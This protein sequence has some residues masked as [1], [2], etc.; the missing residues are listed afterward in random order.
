MNGQAAGNEVSM[1]A[2]SFSVV[3]RVYAGG[4]STLAKCKCSL[5]EF[6]MYN[7]ALT[8]DEVQKSYIRS[9][10]AYCPLSWK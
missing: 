5:T 8:S 9:T 2:F 10:G 4:S 7:R 1:G 3:N 6:E